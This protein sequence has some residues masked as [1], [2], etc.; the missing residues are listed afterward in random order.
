MGMRR[1]PVTEH[2]LS[3]FFGDGRVAVCLSQ[4]KAGG[5]GSVSEEEPQASTAWSGKRALT[6]DLM[7]R[8][9][10]PKN[11]NQAYKK[12]KANGGAAGVDGRKV[13]ELRGWLD[14]HKKDL[15][16]AL[17]T[18]SYQPQPVREVEIPKPG[19]G[20]RQLG[21][22]TVVDRL[23]QQAILQ[24]LEP[25]LDPTF[26]ES[27]YGF[28]PGRSAHQALRQAQD[29]VATGREI[30]VD[31][32][33][34]KFFDR[35]NHDVL[36]SRLARHIGDKRLLRM[37]RR[38]LEAGILRQGVC[39]QRY[40]GT[41]QGGPLSPL[42]ANLLLD[43]L[44]RELERRGHC[45]C[46]YADDCNI[47]MRSEAAG[48]RVMASVTAFLEGRLRLRVN[49]AKSAVARVE[50]RHFLGYRL[51]AGGQL[52]IAPESLRRVKERVR[53]TTQRN[54][55]ASLKRMIRDLNEYLPGW[56]TYFRWVTGDRPFRNLDAWV[57]RRLRCARLKQRKRSHSIA[58]FLQSLG[59]PTR[60]A[61]LLAR[62]G[63]GWWRKSGS[64]QASEAMTNQWFRDQGLIS[65]IDRVAAL[66]R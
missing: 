18:G 36:M 50:E 40:E 59:V 7:E 54:R 13:T 48:Q 66:K 61:W 45:F 47:Y 31:I 21:I 5:T 12:V 22:P 26:S 25:L 6:Q 51:Q 52:G 62:S 56:A 16:E 3:L 55:G 30:V 8:V 42:L 41:P 32:D 35:V 10:D 64:P 17:L 19:G 28:R 11:L 4:D 65:L 49:R 2:Q 44:D 14:E 53:Q 46:R 63:K 1:Q 15:V 9:C 33:L 23:V 24:V 29:Y 57:R 39:V 20:T 38:F 34:E 27:S 43:D 37:I 58:K 60:Q